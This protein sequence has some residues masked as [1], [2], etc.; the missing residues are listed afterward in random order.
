MEQDRK[1]LPQAGPGSCTQ[2]SAS[3]AREYPTDGRDRVFL[4]ASLALGLLA[5]DLLWHFPPGAGVTVLVCAWYACVLAYLGRDCL[6]SG[7]SRFLLAANLL[8]ADSLALTSSWPFREWNCMALPVLLAVH[9]VSLSRAGQRPWWQ[10]AMLPE[11]LWLTL[12]GLFGS[13]G[14]VGSV[15]TAGGR[16]R[17]R[18]ALTAVLGTALA[19]AA[20]L[21]LVP[22]LSSADLLFSSVTEAFRTFLWT[23]LSAWMLRLLIAVVLTPFLFSLLYTLRRPR[24]EKCRP[25]RE[26]RTTDPLLF[27]I[28]LTALDA[29]YLLFISVQT[30][31]LFGGEAYLRARGISYAEWARSGFFQMTGVTAVNLAAVLGAAAFSGRQGRLWGAARVLGGLLLAESGVLLASA[32]WRMSLYVGAYGLSFERCM[33]YWGMAL[34]AVFLALGGRKLALPE[35]CSFCRAAFPIAVCAWL[36]V[37]FTPLD[38]LV[39]Q[40]Q[41]ERYLTGRSS[42]VDTLYLTEI[43]S[44]DALAPL[45]RLKLSPED[46]QRIALRRQAAA[47]ECAS[48]ES[49]NLSAWLASRGRETPP[50]S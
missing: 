48:W 43:L 26:K 30:A 24:E 38:R 5:A 36:A 18:R 29:L 9:A 33:T 37:T 19:A 35:R 20:L 10:P 41:T 22:V 16:A 4:L 13:L 40:N 2:K 32:A 25:V 15:L 17:P 21:V 46:A 7:E 39:A 28:L 47:G 23:H 27:V 49:W 12:E 44:Y 6:R 42:A 31:G 1:V 34:M 3:A 11:R 50:L 8:L 45:D 14:A